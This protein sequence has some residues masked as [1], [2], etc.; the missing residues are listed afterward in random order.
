MMNFHA[1]MQAV[2]K[3]VSPK[4]KEAKNADGKK[5]GELF[6]KNHEELVKAGEKWARDT[7]SSFTLVGTL[8]ITIMFAAAFTV[9]GGNDQ[10]TGIPIF[11][12]K[13][14][15][16]VF[17]LADAISLIMSSSSV[18]IF[19]GILT[20]RYAEKDFLRSLPLKLLFGL[21]TLFFSVAS[22]M[23]AFVAALSMMLKGHRGL[24]IAAMSLAIIPVLVLIP[25]LLSLSF[26]ILKSTLRPNL[27]APKKKKVKHN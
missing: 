6:T 15:F 12:K 4:C 8:I 10:N 13:P 11:L 20:S 3:I 23:L 2:E 14:A 26:E 5:P 9:P 21:I 22:M 7:A 16:T 24:V 18:L 19:I 25:T 27:L 17:I 1:C